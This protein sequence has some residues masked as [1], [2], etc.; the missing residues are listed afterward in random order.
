MVKDLG[1]R[2]LTGIILAGLLVFLCILAAWFCWRSAF[3]WP[4]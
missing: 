2:A 4:A 1:T 3:L